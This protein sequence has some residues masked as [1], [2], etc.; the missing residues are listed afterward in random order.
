[1]CMSMHVEHEYKK[2]NGKLNLG[3]KGIRIF[4]PLRNSLEEL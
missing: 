3:N 1:M 4:V 2:E